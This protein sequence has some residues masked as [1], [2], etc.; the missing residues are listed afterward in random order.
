MVTTPSWKALL[1]PNSLTSILD[2]EMNLSLKTASLWQKPFEFHGTV[3]WWLMCPVTS[4]RS[5]SSQTCVGIHIILS[6]Q[7]KLKTITLYCSLALSGFSLIPTSLHVTSSL[8]WFNHDM[9]WLK[10]TI[11]FIF[12]TSDEL[13]SN[14]GPVWDNN[15]SPLPPENLPKS[16]SWG[17]HQWRP[18]LWASFSTLWS[19]RSRATAMRMRGVRRQEPEGR[20][21]PNIWNTKH[22]N[23]AI[24]ALHRGLG[25]GTTSAYGLSPLYRQFNGPYNIQ[26]STSRITSGVYSIEIP[27]QQ[28][29]I[30]LN[31]V[32]PTWLVC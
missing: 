13:E 11:M 15:N 26:V 24:I 1:S 32:S 30:L 21:S 7:K 27:S 29:Q 23:R 17:R 25:L 10:Q 19:R 2:M 8:T 5:S 18:W 22:H 4:T 28:L 14:Q 3:N 16:C 12:R 6:A 20:G 9:A 31:G